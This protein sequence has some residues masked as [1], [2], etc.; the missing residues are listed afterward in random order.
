MEKKINIKYVKIT[1]ERCEN[2]RENMAERCENTLG[3]RENMAGRCKNMP[4]MQSDSLGFSFHV[5]N[6]IC[7]P[8]DSNYY[9]LHARSAMR[10]LVTVWAIT[11]VSEM[12]QGTQVTIW[13]IHSG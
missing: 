13:V 3:R 12:L 11:S 1:S 10:H 6:P 7:Q 4:E 2:M 9:S 8:G 5:K